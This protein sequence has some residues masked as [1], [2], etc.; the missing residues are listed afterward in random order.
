M[1]R[2]W[3][4]R[5]LYYRY[6]FRNFARVFFPVWKIF[7]HYDIT[8]FVHMRHAYKLKIFQGNLQ[9]RLAAKST[10]TAWILSFLRL[11]AK[12]ILS[13]VLTRRVHRR[14]PSHRRPR[15]LNT[16][17]C[18]LRTSSG[19]SSLIDWF[20]LI[21]VSAEHFKTGLSMF[22]TFGRVVQC[23]PSSRT[24]RQAAPP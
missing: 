2:M 6:L 11:F 22:R 23:G 18:L 21:R 9:S 1:R 5:C 19:A 14:D 20:R 7:M 3:L 10:L 13:C 4:S 24:I 8:L 16:C 15:R 12:W 17:G